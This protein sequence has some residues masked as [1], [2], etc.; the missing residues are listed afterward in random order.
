MSQPRK[1]FAIRYPLLPSS[2]WAGDCFPLHLVVAFLWA[3]QQWFYNN[4]LRLSHS[5]CMSQ[6][7][8][9]SVA[10]S[11]PGTFW[12]LHGYGH[13]RQCASKH[14]RI[15]TSEVKRGFVFVLGRAASAKQSGLRKW[16]NC[17]KKTF[18]LQLVC[19]FAQFGTNRPRCG[20][21]LSSLHTLQHGRAAWT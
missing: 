17:H 2:F 6:H 5:N 14:L 8:G 3:Q 21:P 9:R 13:F 10:I 4:T 18:Q 19:W 7:S 16:T 11:G 1:S 12:L 15:G 20:W